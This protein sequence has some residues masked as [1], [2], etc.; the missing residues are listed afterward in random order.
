MIP[1]TTSNMYIFFFLYKNCVQ[2]HKCKVMATMPVI[3]FILQQ[4][5]TLQ[6]FFP[7]VTQ[8]K[9]PMSPVYVFCSFS[10]I[11]VVVE[12]SSLLF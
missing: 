8:L 6:I 3:S 10:C 11:A 9:L 7:H 4:N 12:N 1:L 2:N 5:G